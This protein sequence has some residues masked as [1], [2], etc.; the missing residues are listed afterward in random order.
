MVT[1][2]LIGL[3]FFLFVYFVHSADRVLDKAGFGNWQA[4]QN[5]NFLAQAALWITGFF[6]LM[7]ILYATRLEKKQ[8]SSIFLICTLSVIAML[9]I[10]FLIL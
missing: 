3:P 5:Y 9:I 1:A 6:W 7:A 4:W 8:R 10:W 2:F